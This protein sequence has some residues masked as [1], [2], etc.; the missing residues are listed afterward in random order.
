M[1]D[2]SIDFTQIAMKATS[3]GRLV[4]KIADD[5]EVQAIGPLTDLLRR[6]KK[7][8]PE[9][10]RTCCEKQHALQVAF[11]GLEAGVP[12][13]AVR[14]FRVEST[15]TGIAVSPES[16]DCPG[17]CPTGAADAVLGEHKAVDLILA[18]RPKFWEEMGILKGARALIEAE[19]AHSKGLLVSQPI[20]ILAFE[21]GV[22]VPH[23]AD[24]GL[25]H[26]R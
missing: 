20:S 1:G 26:L 17:D 2:T 8:R 4:R 13:M 23:W 19:I 12:A 6:I 18:G 3:S 24:P 7:Q 5:F 22:A 16:K 11:I 15:P 9:Y 14:S 21:R 10:F 25:C